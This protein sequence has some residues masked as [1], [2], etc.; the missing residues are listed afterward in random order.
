MCTP[1]CCRAGAAPRR[2]SARS[3]PAT[4][5]PASR[6][7]RWTRGST[8]ARSCCEQAIPIGPKE[9]AGQ[10]GERLAALGARL[11]VEALDGLARGMLAAASAAERGRDLRREA[12][13]RR[14]PARLAPSRRRAGA[15][16]ARLRSVARRLFRGARRA[17]PRAAPPKP[18]RNAAPAPP[19]TVLDERLSIACG[20]GVFRPLR[21]QRAGRAPLDTPPFC[22]VSRCRPERYCRAPLQADDR[23]LRHRVCRLAAPAE[24][25]VDPGGAGNSGAPLLR[26]ERRPCSAPGA[27]MPA[28]TRWRRSRMSICRA[29]PR[30]TRSAA[31]VNHHLKPHAI[32]V[33]AVEPVSS[34][35][36]ARLSATGRRYLYRILN[37]RAPPALDRGRVWHVA[38][39]LDVAAMREG[40]APPDRASRF[41]DLPRL[42]CA[43]RN[44]RSRRST[45]WT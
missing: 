35:F 42:R 43:R 4:P 30:P 32:S 7:C 44:R 45:R 20:E 16:G 14:G 26:R 8:P 33:L 22:A 29:P 5:R 36:D 25:A 21:L 24:R 38:P 1:R 10:L 41:L 34:D 27:P 6:S 37:R 39:P 12:A 40:A 17:H 9:T 15:A 11:I 2:S 18:T 3:W 31:R 19:G 13:P 28:C 23:V